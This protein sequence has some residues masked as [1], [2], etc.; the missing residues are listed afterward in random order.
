MS[1]FLVRAWLWAGVRSYRLRG[2]RVRGGEGSFRSWSRSRF[3][4]KVVGVRFRSLSASRSSRVCRA[5]LLVAIFSSFPTIFSLLLR[6]LWRTKGRWGGG[7]SRSRPSSAPWSRFLLPCRKT[8]PRRG[9]IQCEWGFPMQL[10]TDSILPSLVWSST[11]FPGE[12]CRSLYGSFPVG[13]VPLR[14]VQ[15]VPVLPI[16]LWANEWLP[17]YLGLLLW[18]SGIWVFQLSGTGFRWWFPSLSRW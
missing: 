11:T 18:G 2:V 16:L 6:A 13:S 15:R 8:S 4:F 17:N 3:Q 12:R 14:G 5:C 10:P 9:A 1:T 7:R